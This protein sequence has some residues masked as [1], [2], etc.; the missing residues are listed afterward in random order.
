VVAAAKTWGSRLLHSWESSPSIPPYS[1]PLAAEPQCPPAVLPGKE[2]VI[3][4]RGEA[5]E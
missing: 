3:I 2:G 1:V 5:N 4:G